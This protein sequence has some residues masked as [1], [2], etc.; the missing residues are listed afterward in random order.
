MKLEVTGVPSRPD[1]DQLNDLLFT[2]GA[3]RPGLTLQV[4]G[5]AGYLATLDPTPLWGLSCNL[6]ME[7]LRDPT[8]LAVAPSFMEFAKS[9]NPRTMAHAANTIGLALAAVESGF[10]YVSGT[11]IHLSQDTPRAPS[12]LHP[13]TFPKRVSG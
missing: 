5:N 13:L 7:Q 2:V 12:R 6:S 9:N 11:A 10:T 4:A 3:M 8:H 1:I